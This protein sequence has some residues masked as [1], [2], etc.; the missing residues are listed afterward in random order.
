MCSCQEKSNLS[1]VVGSQPVHVSFYTDVH[2]VINRIITGTQP[3]GVPSAF[4]INLLCKQL[5]EQQGGTQLPGYRW[6]SLHKC[7]S[8][9]L[10]GFQTCIISCVIR[11]NDSVIGAWSIGGVSCD[12]S[13]GRLVFSS[14]SGSGDVTFQKSPSALAQRPKRRQNI[15]SNK[16]N[17]GESTFIRGFWWEWVFSVNGL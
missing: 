10:S 3:K 4:I 9:W 5:Q 2:W 15:S 7:K 6:Q 14:P 1:G 17:Q 8:R 12:V 13:N 11:K 16:T